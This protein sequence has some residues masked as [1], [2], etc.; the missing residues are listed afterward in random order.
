MGNIYIFCEGGLG[1]RIN[2]LINGLFLSTELN[3]KLILIWPQTNTCRT[4]FKDIFENHFTIE[5]DL[6]NF[7]LKHHESFAWYSHYDLPQY[8]KNNKIIDAKSNLLH[9]QGS[10]A[11]NIFYSQSELM[12]SSSLSKKY[13]SQLNFKP[14]LIRKALNIIPETDFTGLH[15]RSTDYFTIPEHLYYIDESNQ[16]EQLFNEIKSSNKLYFVCSDDIEVE[17]KFNKLDNVFINCKT[18]YVKKFH[19][20]KQWFLPD[21]NTVDDFGRNIIYNVERDNQ[22]VLDAVVDLLVLSRSNIIKTSDS[23]FLHIAKL[24]N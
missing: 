13:L 23:S 2:T 11:K 7:Y 16:F 22:S 10:N 1:N 8:I 20:S 19:Q 15:L 4:S 21:R 17:D 14:S 12:L 6:L 9:M 5:N 3:R 24:L 18:S